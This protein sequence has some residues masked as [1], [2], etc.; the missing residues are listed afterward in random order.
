MTIS[1]LFVPIGLYKIR[2]F[3]VSDLSCEYSSGEYIGFRL[4]TIALGF[5]FVVPYAFF[6]CQQSSLLPCTSIAYIS[7]L[8]SWLMC[9]MALIKSWKYDLLRYVDAA[10]GYFVSTGVLCR[11]VYFTFS[12]VE[13]RSDDCGVSPRGD[14]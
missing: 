4:I 10:E 11:N 6:T 13:Y 9:F 14:C 12:C 3:Q 7:Q 1:N 5:V 8:K 2:S